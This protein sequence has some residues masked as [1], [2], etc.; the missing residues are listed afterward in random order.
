MKQ[1]IRAI[2]NTLTSANLF[3]GCC[4]VYAA[5]MGDYT[6]V[7][8]LILA[9][10]VFDF[11]DGF[12]ARIL[13][14]YSPIGAQLDSLADM[15][16]FGVA[17]ATVV[18]SLLTIRMDMAVI[19]PWYAFVAFM[20]AVFAALRLAKFNIDTRQSEEFRGLPTPAMALFFTS[21]AVSYNAVIASDSVVLIYSLLGL[22]AIFCALMVCDV[23][24]FSFKFKSFS[25]QKNILRYSFAAFSVLMIVLL[26]VAA[27]AVIILA[28]ILVSL[29]RAIVLKTAEI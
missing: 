8:W 27:P 26:G 28:Y 11:F 6:S 2:P 17:P 29:V 19:T 18:F 9:A 16:S 1:I 7:F 10:A 5:V 12:A 23:R 3:C 15:V 4:A 21:F 20:L 22:V 25:V 14:A 24:M 13:R